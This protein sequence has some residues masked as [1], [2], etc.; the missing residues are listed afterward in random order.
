VEVSVA[1]LVQSLGYS[2]PWTKRLQITDV[3]E[4][5]AP[6]EIVIPRGA[7]TRPINLKT[8]RRHRVKQDHPHRS[9]ALYLDTRE[10]DGWHMRAGSWIEQYP[11]QFAPIPRSLIER[12]ARYE[13]DLWIK[14]LGRELCYHYRE[15]HKESGPNRILKVETMLRRMCVLERVKTMVGERHGARALNYL[16][17]ALNT[18]CNIG[19][20]DSWECLDAIDWGTHRA[21]DQWLE[22][23]ISFVPPAQDRMEAAS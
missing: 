21:I 8:G 14:W 1:E 10:I 19:V 17:R 15:S 3:V 18:L 23:R 2:Q 13:P 4:G 11:R 20:V 7:T 22:A 6:L 12:P 9:Y 16:A 5:L